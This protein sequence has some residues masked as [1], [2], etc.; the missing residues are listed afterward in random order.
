MVSGKENPLEHSS[1]KLINI[2]DYECQQQNLP[3]TIFFWDKINE[4][5]YKWTDICCI[6][7]I[8][9]TEPK[10]AKIF[11]LMQICDFFWWGEVGVWL[12]FRE[13]WLSLSTIQN[14]QYIGADY[15]ILNHSTGSCK[16]MSTI[17]WVL[18]YSECYTRS[19]MLELKMY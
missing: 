19:T 8:L 10:L 6:R 5:M 1:I 2:H 17:P 18:I 12:L 11:W 3:R 13:F 14:L 16:V 15:W 4:W 9:H 7:L